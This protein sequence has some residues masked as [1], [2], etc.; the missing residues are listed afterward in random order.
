[1]KKKRKRF[2]LHRETLRRLDD[3]SLGQVAGGGGTYEIQ[4]TCACTDGC[5]TGSTCQG[6]GT[7][8]GCGGTNDTCTCI[9]PESHCYC[10]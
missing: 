6:C 9:I 10:P 4:T 3:D 2:Q 8:D 5:G 1:M 7:H